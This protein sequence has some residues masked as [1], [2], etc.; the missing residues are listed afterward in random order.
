MTTK[1]NLV[2]LMTNQTKAM[3]YQERKIFRSELVRILPQSIDRAAR[4]A[5]AARLQE[6]PDQADQEPAG[7]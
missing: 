6:E 7:R 4:V 3:S 2:E 5:L 1:I